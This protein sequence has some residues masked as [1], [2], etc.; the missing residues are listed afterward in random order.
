MEALNKVGG[1]P[2]VEL[3]LASYLLV[4]RVKFQ[5]GLLARNSPEL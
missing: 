3:D 2:G 4:W 1:K 5:K